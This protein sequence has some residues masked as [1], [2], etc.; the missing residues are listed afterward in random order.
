MRGVVLETFGAGNAPERADLYTVF[1][2]VG[3][4]TLHITRSG[5]YVC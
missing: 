3:D 4:Y 1:Q 2:E 5:A